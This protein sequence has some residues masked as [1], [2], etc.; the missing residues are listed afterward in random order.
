[1]SSPSTLD[2]GVSNEPLSAPVLSIWQHCVPAT[3]NSATIVSR[4]W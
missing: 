2:A 4:N 3:S 1:M